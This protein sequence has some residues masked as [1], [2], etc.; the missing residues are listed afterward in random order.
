MPQATNKFSTIMIAQKMFNGLI[1]P[2]MEFIE[3]ASQQ[4]LNRQKVEKVLEEFNKMEK[5][6][7]EFYTIQINKKIRQPF[8]LQIDQEQYENILKFD[9]SPSRSLFLELDEIK[10][11]VIQKMKNLPTQFPDYTYYRSLILDVVRY[12]GPFQINEDDKKFYMDNFKSIFDEKFIS[13]V[14]DIE[15]IRFF[16]NL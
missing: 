13:K 2:K 8:N 15:T 16:L 9:I 14:V 6:L 11:K 12:R 10:A 1:R 5:F 3:F 7:T 4:N